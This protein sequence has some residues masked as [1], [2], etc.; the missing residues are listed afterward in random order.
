MTQKFTKK[1]SKK[2]NPKLQ[3]TIYIFMWLYVSLMIKKKA[4]QNLVINYE[5]RQ[6]LSIK[7]TYKWLESNILLYM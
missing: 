6:I 7:N 2:H 3:I 4:Q 5:S 1:I